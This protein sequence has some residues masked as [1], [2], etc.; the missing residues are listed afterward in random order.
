GI[1]AQNRFRK[2]SSDSG[3]PKKSSC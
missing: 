1:H 2:Y 3:S